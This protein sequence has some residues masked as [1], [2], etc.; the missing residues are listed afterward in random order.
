MNDG[1]LKK[2]SF[3][4]AKEIVELYKFLSQ[5]KKE[6]VLSRQMLRSGTNPGA[7]IREAINAESKA[8]FIHKLKIAQKEAIE[9][10]YWLE[11]LLETDYINQAQ[12]TKLNNLTIEIMKMTASSIL[13]LNKK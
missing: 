9:T 4:L 8:D 1:P 7:M 3:Q 13:T 5:E 10:Q 6:F 12:F 2:K 11:L